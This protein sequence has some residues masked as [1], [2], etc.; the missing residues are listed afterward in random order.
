M[1]PYVPV[2]SVPAWLATTGRTLAAAAVVAALAGSWATAGPGNGVLV[3]SRDAVALPR[4]VV[5]Q[6]RATA[7]AGPPGT[8][9]CAAN[10]GPDTANMGANGVTLRQ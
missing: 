6:E 8:V 10:G 9:Q 5:V 1:R 3:A 7:L 4:V 2:S